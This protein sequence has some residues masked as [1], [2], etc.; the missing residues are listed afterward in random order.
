MRLHLV[1]DIHPFETNLTPSGFHCSCGNGNRVFSLLK[2]DPAN[3][4]RNMVSMEDNLSQVTIPTFHKRK[5][6]KTTHKKSEMTN[7]A[8]HASLDSLERGRRAENVHKRSRRKIME[9]LKVQEKDRAPT[10]GA[11]EDDEK[12]EVE[13]KIVALQRIIPGG[14]SLG[15]DELFEETADYI[16]TLQCQIKAMRVLSGFLEGLEKEKRKYGG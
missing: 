16:M 13:R 15:V 5:E 4:N 11:G 1:T 7:N 10:V 12:A 9:T 3:G 14:E 8:K 2:V 6:S